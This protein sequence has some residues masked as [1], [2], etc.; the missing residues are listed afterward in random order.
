[1]AFTHVQQGNWEK[2][3]PDL[4]ILLKEDPDN[5][6]Y[7]NLT[8]HAFLNVGDY[9]RA[10]A[11]FEMWVSKHPAAESWLFYGYALATV[12]RP[13]DSIAPY[14]EAISRRPDMGEAYWCLSNLKIYRFTPSEIIAM[15]EALEFGELDARSRWFMHFALGKAFEDARQYAES[16]EQYR[17]GN[18]LV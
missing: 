8:A 1:H 16:F 14:R 18:A 6:D 2:A 13:Q 17:K 3:L 9:D 10:I 15:R 11:C 7:L 5:A 12:G 4:E